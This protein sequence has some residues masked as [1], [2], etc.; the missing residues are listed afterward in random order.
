MISV[1]K[2]DESL[3]YESISGNLRL[4]KENDS[5]HIYDHMF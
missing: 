5:Y 3:L 4:E 2:G 1:T